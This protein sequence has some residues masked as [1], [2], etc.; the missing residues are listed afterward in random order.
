MAIIIVT[1][2]REFEF[3]FEFLRG[4]F[5]FGKIVV[6]LGVGV[7]FGFGKQGLLGLFPCLFS[8]LP[9]ALAI[10][11]LARLFPVLCR[12]VLFDGGGRREVRLGD[13]TFLHPGQTHVGTLEIPNRGKVFPIMIAE[14]QR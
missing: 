2:E 7:G 13:G 8:F 1:V 10:A 3:D 11:I 5:R 9:F 4:D 12:F 14:M 6:V